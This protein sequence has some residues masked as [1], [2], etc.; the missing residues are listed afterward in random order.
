MSN[1]DG[2]VTSTP[3]PSDHTEATL[4]P[5]LRLQVQASVGAGID[6][7]GQATSKEILEARGGERPEGKLENRRQGTYVSSSQETSKPWPESS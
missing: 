7:H 2:P 6:G 5:D 3:G 4:E 1:E